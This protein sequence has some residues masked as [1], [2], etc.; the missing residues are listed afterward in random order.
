MAESSPRRVPGLA[1]FARAELGHFP[2]PV[3]ALPRLGAEL[4]VE[5]RVKR[6]D[7]TGLA[8]G[9]NKIRQLEF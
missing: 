2:T 9:G 3:D 7:C 6:D 8:F 1:A 5:L 4:G